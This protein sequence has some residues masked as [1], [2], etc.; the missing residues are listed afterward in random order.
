MAPVDIYQYG[1]DASWELDL[2]GRVR[3]SIE[4][5]DASIDASAEARRNV[6]L[7]TLAEVARDYM[8]LRGVQQQI[9]IAERNVG[10]QQQTVRLTQDR[11][12]G[13]LGTDLDVANAAAQLRTTQA[14]LPQLHQQ[15]AQLINALSLLLA[16]LIER[17]G[18]RHYFSFGISTEQEGHLLNGGLVAQKEYFGARGI[19]HDF[20]EWEL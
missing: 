20:Y 6:L 2:W 7:S 15:E 11:A 5:S 18:E 16:D 10:L 12:S 14:Q 3:R 1:F 9:D 13:G 17:Y 8:Q 19:A 4:S